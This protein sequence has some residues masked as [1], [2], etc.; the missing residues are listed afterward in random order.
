MSNV[1]NRTLQS[2]VCFVF[3]APTA[4]AAEPFYKDK[5][6]TLVIGFSP[7][8]GYDS[9]ARAVARHIPAH[10]EG[11]P[12]VIVQNMPGAGSLKAV[13]S[14]NA[15]L[16]TDATTML[17][18][19]PGLITQS[20]VDPARVGVN[21]NDYKWIGIVT[22]DF[23][24]CYGYGPKGIKNWDELASGKKFVLGATGKGSGSYINGAILREVFHL[25]VQQIIGFPGS[26][27]QRLAIQRGELDGDCGSFSS[28]PID[29]LK[30]GLA[31]P[32]VRFTK[33]KQEGMPDQA[34]F[35]EDKA[36]SDEQR[37]LL[38]VL[39]AEDEVGR[40][41]IVSGRVPSDRVDALRT[42]FSDTMKDKDFL[43]E[44]QTLNL[45]VN[46]VSGADAQRIVEGMKSVS[47]KTRLAAQK[48]YE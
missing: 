9:Y 46:P 48:I 41:L 5:T 16:P 29:W 21:F 26:A 39:D 44:M 34:I 15:T 42:A 23:R 38:H 31:H 8:G 14:L 27:D 6:I 35:I 28:I 36:T 40:S 20:I 45:P 3:I 24:V 13:Q 19:N 30:Q 11:R 47:E 37:S 2:L 32:F 1:L 7:G 17:T 25:P 43:A 10:I 4:V 33:Q 12:D 18:F 22:P